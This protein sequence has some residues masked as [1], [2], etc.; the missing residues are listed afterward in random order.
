MNV[1][2]D[3]SR[4]TPAAF[5]SVTS[6]GGSCDRISRGGLRIR[7]LHLPV[8]AAIEGGH[9]SLFR[10]TNSWW[11]SSKTLSNAEALVYGRMTWN[12]PFRDLRCLHRISWETQAST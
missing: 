5:S 8:I 6:S 2:L 10:R 4:R 3:Y 12:G 11:P 1:P 7:A 9:V